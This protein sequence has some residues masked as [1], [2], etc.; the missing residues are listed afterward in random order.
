MTATRAGPTR[1]A[2]SRHERCRRDLSTVSGGADRATQRRL[3]TSGL[4]VLAR[5]CRAPPSQA[6]RLCSCRGCRCATFTCRRS[7]HGPHPGLGR[8]DGISLPRHCRDQLRAIRTRTI[9]DAAVTCGLVDQHD[10]RP[11]A[12]VEDRED[13]PDDVEL[14]VERGAGEGR[15]WRLR[16]RGITIRAGRGR[17]EGLAGRVSCVVCCSGCHAT[18]PAQDDRLRPVQA[19][20]SD[21]RRNGP[22][23]AR[24]DRSPPCRGVVVSPRR[25]E[26][27]REGGR[28]VS[29]LRGR[30]RNTGRR[31][32]RGRSQRLCA[33]RSHASGV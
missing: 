30:V 32:T 7:W 20:T 23:K 1:P 21:D 12:G 15:C 16:G 6:I 25:R 29:A 2:C 22:T 11:A 4:P 9:E 17:R 5:M 28:P 31:S 14:L 24:C 26:G 27:V 3:R 33:D 10:R 18:A 13:V 8:P 19:T